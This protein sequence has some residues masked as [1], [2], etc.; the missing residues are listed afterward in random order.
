MYSPLVRKGGAIAFHDIVPDFRTRFG[1]PTTNDVG[2][3]PAFWTELKH[4][5]GKTR[6]FVEDASQDGYG[7]GLLEWEGT[8]RA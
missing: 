2:E 5:V 6:E 1:T 4:R 3:V 7:I 8:G